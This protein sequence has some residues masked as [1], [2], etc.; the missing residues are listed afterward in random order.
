M[1]KIRFTFQT[2]ILILFTL[3]FTSFAQAQATRTWVSGVGDDVNPCSRTA[4]C[5]TFAGAIS[6]TFI[7]G[8]IDCLDPGGF[9]ALTITKS[10]TID[11]TGTFGSVLASGTTGFTINIAAN[12]NDPLR[13]VTLRGLSINGTGSSGAIGTRTGINGVNITLNGANNVWIEDCVIFNFSQN[14]INANNP[15]S[16]VNIFLK[17]DVLRDNGGAGLFTSS[18]NASFFIRASADHCHF[19]GNQNGI[20]AGSNS[21]VFATNCVLD[22]NTSNGLLVLNTTAGL[23]SAANL[24][25]CEVST[26]LGNGV[27]AGGAG[28]AGTSIARIGDNLITG[29]LGNGVL[30]GATGQVFTYQDNELTGNNVD[31]CPG[32]IT[33]TPPKN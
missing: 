22:G 7:N 27:L 16:S 30:V 8:E 29:N 12:V 13:N 24:K 32:C 25:S 6:K 28:S 21:R 17:N 9:G 3:A 4:P 14:G 15:S 1:N 18:N 5:K 23:V 10:I 11:S 19:T 20:K 2:L 26:N 31:G 33:S